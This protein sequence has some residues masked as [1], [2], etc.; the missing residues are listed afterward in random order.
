MHTTSRRKLALLLG[1]VLAVVAASM[2]GLS[3]R[4]QF[5]L[6]GT[7]VE[8]PGPVAHAGIGV[9]GINVAMLDWEPVARRGALQ[10]LAEM[11]FGWV[12]QT[13]YWGD[14]AAGFGPFLQDALNVGLAV[15]P[16]L[17]GNPQTGYTPPEDPAGFAAW[18]G[19][20]AAEHGQHVRYYQ[21]WDEPNLGSHWGGLPVN[22][23]AYAALLAAARDAI[24][25]ADPDAVMVAAALAPTVESGPTNLSDVDYLDGLYRAGADAFFDVAAGK[26]YGF[27]TGPDDRRISE[28]VLNFSRFVLL[29]EV[30]ERHGDGDTALWAGNLGWNAL[31]VGWAGR[32]SI[33]GQTDEVTQAVY[34]REAYRRAALEWPW[35][36]VLFLESYAPEAP[37]GWLDRDLPA[38]ESPS[39]PRWGFALLAPDGTLRHDSPLPASGA[40]II[41]GFQLAAPDSPYQV[42]DGGW[43]FQDGYGADVSQSGDRVRVTFEGTDF[44]IRVRR[45]DYRAYFYV[46]VDGQPANSLPADDRGAYLC[47]TSPDRTADDVVTVLAAKGLAPGRHTAELVA[48]RGWDQWALVG[49]SAMTLPNQVAYRLTLAGLASLA[50]AVAAAALWAG[51]GSDWGPWIGG[52]RDA[53][54]RLGDAGAAVFTAL[55]AGLFALSGWLTWLSP[56]SGPFRRLGD[57]PQTGLLLLVAALF[58]WSPWLLLNLASGAVLWLIIMWRLELGLA[59]V[60]LSA[61]F[62]VLPKPMLGYRFSMVEVVV[63]M[64]FSSWAFERIRQWRPGTRAKWVAARRLSLDYAIGLFVLAALMS[65]IFTERLDVA[66]NEL[67]VVV[68]EPALFYLMLRSSRLDGRSRWRVLD[69]LVLGGLGVALAGLLW[70]V[71]GSHVITAEAG[72][73]RLRSIY[74]SPNNVGLY[75][76][77]LIPV[78]LAVALAGRGRRRAFYAF[79]LLPSVAAVALSFS[80]GALLLG[81]PVGV[82]LVVGWVVWDRWSHRSVI[83]VA[84]GVATL[85]ALGMLLAS[86][87]PALAGRLALRGD[88]TDFRLNL[89]KASAE[90]VAD[91]PWTGVGLDNFLYQYRGRYIRPEAWQEPDL[92][93]P[94]NL[95]LD[96]WLR[97]G[98]L[99]LVAGIWMHGACWRL[100]WRSA[101]RPEGRGFTDSRVLAIGCLG[102]LGAALAHGL[103]DQSYFLVDLAF[104]FMLLAS[105]AAAFSSHVDTQAVSGDT[106][107]NS[108]ALA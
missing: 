74:G 18:A 65:L 47:L 59:L 107:P 15:V 88:T 33:W 87:V 89:W 86:Q 13:V 8:L 6:R 79:A 97:L 28:D 93:H 95:V 11:G 23:A 2:V 24:L 67:R 10:Q 60:A 53:W 46:T 94:H 56:A 41:P 1:L 52:I 20:W 50:L 48:E 4:Q 31:P 61:P 78:L 63:W 82:T 38:A 85:A 7:P 27:D 84:L 100:L 83:R 75:L 91:H 92:S 71:T 102:S 49:F 73:P 25:Q 39:D 62:Y 9:Y 72:L 44:G 54:C 16:L 105:V 36:G 42:Y 45:G 58:S 57:G 99:G 32:P 80:K 43:R 104:V 37:V 69:G 76:G 34:I 77:R 5:L 103:V 17:D 19:A 96:F 26:P 108:P 35:A 98:I 51:R 55:V 81:L 68:L 12:K 90:M 30:M 101:R 40:A 106:D 21:I 14:E 22:P 3:A 29:R 70:Y 64:A 66:A